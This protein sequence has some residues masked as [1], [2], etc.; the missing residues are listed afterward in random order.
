MGGSRVVLVLLAAIVAVG[1]GG[2]GDA[3]GRPTATATPSATAGGDRGPRPGAGGGAP[4]RAR[5]VRLQRVGAFASPVH[6]TA[7]PGDTARVIV[8]EQDGRIRV[9]PRRPGA[10]RA[11]PR[12][13]RPR[14]RRRRAGPALAGLRARL[15]RVR[16]LL[17]L[18]HGPRGRPARRRV[19]RARDADRA[20]AGSARLLLRMAD[21]EVQPQRRPARVRP[22]R[23]A[24]HRHGRRRRR[25]RPA[26]A[27]GNAQNLGSLLGKILRIDPRGRRRRRL[28][29]ARRATRSSRAR[30]ARGEIYAY[31]LRNPWRFSFDRSDGRPRHRR[32]RPGRVGGD[33]LRAPR[34][35]PRARTSAGGRS[36]A[37]RATRPASRAPGHVEPVIVQSH[38]TGTA[39]SRAASS[40]ATPASA[41]RGRYVFG[42]F[43]K[44]RIY[45]AKLARG[46][47]RGV[48]ADLAAGRRASPR[49]ARTPAAA[50]TSPR[51]TG[52]VYRIASK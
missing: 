6:V 51:S 31:G 19:P 21:A 33:R 34:P 36:R 39:R 49:S 42:D 18:L 23:A 43:C 20:D 5:G 47:A 41:L 52:P 28:P 2:G 26:R 3:A 46:R 10:R 32:R 40:S 8:V 45:Q 4:P 30:G 9:D 25:R 7:P 37:A 50:S 16:P 48:Q 29:R 17:R 35:R 12:H 13:P 11:V 27:R 38:A 1:C 24:L 15:R 22:R 14:D 44:G